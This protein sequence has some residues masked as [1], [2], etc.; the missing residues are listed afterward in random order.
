MVLNYKS[1][2][3]SNWS[4]LYCP[5]SEWGK[6]CKICI[7]LY[8]VHGYISKL[9]DESSFNSNGYYSDLNNAINEKLFDVTTIA[10]T[11]YT[12]F[13]SSA[14]NENDVGGE[15]H[16]LNGSINKYYDPYLNK[17]IDSRKINDV[18]EKHFVVPLLFTQSG[19]K[20]MTSIDMS[21]E[22]VDF[23]NNLQKA[24]MICSIGFGFNSDDEHINGIIRTLLIDY[25]KKLTVIEPRRFI[26]ESTRKEQIGNKL[27]VENFE[28]ITVIFVDEN[29]IC[30]NGELW[31][32]ILS[33]K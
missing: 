12:S 4:Y 32:K 23:Y 26:S 9:C 33:Q 27:K 19:T 3:D 29:R 11:N 7:F 5:K 6:F 17:I 14:I 15:I 22:Y 10:T 30:E 21:R 24:D 28:N 13:I 20:P 16:F 18:H 2:I 25:E 8:T 31:T 1:L